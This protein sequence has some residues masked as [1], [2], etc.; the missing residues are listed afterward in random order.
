MTSALALVAASKWLPVNAG[1][2]SAVKR[3][4]YNPDAPP[5]AP[6]KVVTLTL[7]RQSAAVS[8]SRKPLDG[9]LCAALCLCSLFHP[10]LPICLPPPRPRP[11][12]ADAT[13]K[14]AQLERGEEGPLRPKDLL[15][16]RERMARDGRGPPLQPSSATARERGPVG[17]GRTS[18]SGARLIKGNAI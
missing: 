8:T 17:G 9:I 3:D 5:P 11:S 16:A 1:L 18:G 13:A 15:E 2:T 6:R 14:C 10:S 12:P 4:G 7:R